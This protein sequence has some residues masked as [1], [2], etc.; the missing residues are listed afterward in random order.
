MSSQKSEGL[1]IRQVDFSE[2][3]KVITLYT[4]DFG[5]MSY[6]AKGARR[7]KSSFESGLDLLA[8]CQIVFLQKSGN[9]LHL[10]TES[11]LKKRFLP[12]QSNILAYYGGYYFAELLDKLLLDHVPQPELFDFTIQSLSQLME[13]PDPRPVI[14][15]FEIFLLHELGHLPSFDA[16]LC[17]NSIQQE[18][19]Y[20]FWVSQGTILCPTCRSQDYNA[21]SISGRSL[22]ALQQLC[23][24][25][26]N[27]AAPTETLT[28]STSTSPQLPLGQL[29]EIQS[30]L[31]S[32]LC[33]LMEK[34][35]RLLRYLQF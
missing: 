3:S 10:L 8:Y 25:L 1:V 31:V 21:K 29:R 28:T 19:S 5:K 17:G 6:L 22:C 12:Q 24:D 27:P 15:A 14:V 34:Q 35:P 33:F 30:L 4:R 9:G 16:C 7:L 26:L 13:E 2:T 20:A 23:E 18:T 32:C 11:R